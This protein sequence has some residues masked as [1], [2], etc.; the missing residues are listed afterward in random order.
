[1]HSLR[2]KPMVDVTPNH[3]RIS[4]KER[5]SWPRNFGLLPTAAISPQAAAAG[6]VERHTGRVHEDQ[7][8]IAK[9]IAAALEQTLLKHR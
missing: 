4:E 7:R 5:P 8:Q 1:I 3:L 6:A 9:Q 2:R